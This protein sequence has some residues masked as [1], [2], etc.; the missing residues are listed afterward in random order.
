MKRILCPS[1]NAFLLYRKINYEFQ[2]LKTAKNTLI[3]IS[4]GPAPS[5]LT[6]DIYKMGYQAIDIGHSDT[7]DT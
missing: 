1:E 4:L 7:S 3:L 5:V 2:R 6:Y